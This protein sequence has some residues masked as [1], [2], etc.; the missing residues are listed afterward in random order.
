MS[1]TLASL[2]MLFCPKHLLGRTV[3]LFYVAI[4]DCLKTHHELPEHLSSETRIG[5]VGF[6]LF[7]AVPVCLSLGY[8]LQLWII[9]VSIHVFQ[10]N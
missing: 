8:Y 9:H 10:I 2:W 3:L 1:Y 6:F 7:G 5:W 4:K